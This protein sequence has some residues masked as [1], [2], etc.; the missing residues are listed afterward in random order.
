MLSNDLTIRHS[1][2]MFGFIEPQ[3]KESILIFHSCSTNLNVKE[4]TGVLCHEKHIGR[5][6]RSIMTKGTSTRRKSRSPEPLYGNF[7]PGNRDKLMISYSKDPSHDY[8][9]AESCGVIYQDEINFFGGDVYVEQSF[10]KQHFV[11]ETHRNGRM[12]RMT[13][14]KDLEERLIPEFEIFEKNKYFNN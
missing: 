6:P 2:E 3:V 13:K 11:M 5:T 14:K 9:L 12:V 4:E 1:C 7:D 8:G 10:E